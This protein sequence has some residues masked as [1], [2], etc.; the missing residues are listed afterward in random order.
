MK[1]E[2]AHRSEIVDCRIG[3]LEM[4]GAIELRLGLVDCRIGSLEIL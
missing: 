2:R 1:K 4:N 3:S